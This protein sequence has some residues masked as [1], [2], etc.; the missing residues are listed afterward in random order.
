MH[1]QLP[2]IS[3]AKD[4]ILT[5]LLLVLSALLF[6]G[7]NRGGIDSIR[8]V[9]ITLFSYLEEPISNVQVYRQALK[10]NSDL[11]EQNIRLLDELNRLRSAR[12]RN[13]E[14][15]ELLQFSRNSDLSLYPAQIIGKELNQV[16]NVFTIDAG[17]NDGIEEGMPMVA[18]DG[19]IG[20]VVLASDEYAQVMPYFNTLFK[21]SASLQNSN[22]YGI[23]SWNGDENI[24][25][26]ELKYVPQTVPVDTGETVLTSGFSNQFP[27]N[28]PVGKVIRHVPEEGK[29]TQRIFI[30]PFVNIY[31]VSEGFVVTTKPDTAV[32]NLIKEYQELFK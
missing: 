9:T 16:H 10:T 1:F 28:I 26:L 8:K 22:A 21:V 2:Q 27:P 25:E 4:Y 20:K 12:Q 13:R 29:D 7:N 23:V 5:A 14:L 31:T 32:K 30:Q 17:T 24:D 19:L 15:T 18:A 3:E 6:I 11:R